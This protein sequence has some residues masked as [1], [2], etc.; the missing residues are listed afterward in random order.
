M[1]LLL[2]AFDRLEI[3]LQSGSCKLTLAVTAKERTE[4]QQLFRYLQTFL[5]IICKI[6]RSR[7][8]ICWT[9]KHM[10]LIFKNYLNTNQPQGSLSKSLTL[11]MCL[12]PLLCHVCTEFTHQIL[13]MALPSFPHGHGQEEL[14]CKQRV[15]RGVKLSKRNSLSWRHWKNTSGATTGFCCLCFL[16]RCENQPLT[17][18]C[19]SWPTTSF[20]ELSVVYG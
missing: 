8:Q 4:N 20:S 7:P 9:Q 10:I 13:N 1:V 11:N 5:H 6:T 2:K 19:E 14:H 12:R 3:T 17:W 16:G 18:A 15:Y